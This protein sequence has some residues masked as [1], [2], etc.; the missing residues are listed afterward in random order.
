MNEFFQVCAIASVSGA[1]IL[2]VS[3]KEKEFSMLT[4]ALLYILACIYSIEK[5]QGLRSMFGS[6][7]IESKQTIPFELIY[8]LFGIGFAGAA[9]A[10]ICET[11]GQKSL[12]GVIDL[13]TVIEIFST[14]FPYLED[15]MTKILYIFNT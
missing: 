1:I 12:V 10:A 11:F 13:I 9:A 4:T 7:L 6:F 2:F 5:L 14:A 8:K 15:M 3:G